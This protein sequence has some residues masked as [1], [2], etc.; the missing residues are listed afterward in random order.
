MD[1]LKNYKIVR[2]LV[3]NKRTFI[4][5]RG[6]CRYCGKHEGEVKFKKVAHSFP[7]LIGN[8]FLFSRDECDKCNEYFD[9]FLENNLANFLGIARTTTR[10][11]GKKGVPKYK[12]RDG[13]RIE[14]IGDA[15]LA[16]ESHD[17]KMI[18]FDEDRQLLSINV[19]KG[20]YTPIQVYKC[21]VKMAIAIM[22]DAELKGYK[23]CIEWIRGNKRPA[24]FDKSVLRMYRTFVPGV[25]PFPLILA[26]LLKRVGDKKR[27]PNMTCVIAFNN[28]MFHFVV[29]FC[30]KDKFFDGGKFEFVNFPII[31]GM[32]SG[33]R[34]HPGVDVVDLT[35]DS[36][37]NSG[38]SAHMKICEEFVEYSLD[39][40]PDK[41]KKRVADLGLEFGPEGSGN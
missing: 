19:E 10:V 29:P 38:D 31:S 41:I 32:L 14:A 26:T 7:E 2:T 8:K 24:K 39:E 15:I 6:R 25:R 23:Q 40:V 9:K 21:F 18:E 34:G 17:S 28:L 33:Q 3:L 11:D 13:E 27:H 37:I 12:S 1:I 4:G 16:I 5:E 30:S 22:P 36:Q 20:A 35:G